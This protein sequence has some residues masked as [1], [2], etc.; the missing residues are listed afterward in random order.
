VR[1]PCMRGSTRPDGD[2]A[3]SGPICPVA[4]THAGNDMVRRVHSERI[5]WSASVHDGHANMEYRCQLGHEELTVSSGCA[6]P[7]AGVPGWNA[8]PRTW[9]E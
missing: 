8:P 3:S 9:S 7:V 1:K 4:T 5:T 2:T 6:A